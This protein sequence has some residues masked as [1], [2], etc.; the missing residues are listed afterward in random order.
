M[1]S[2]LKLERELQ[3][4]GIPLLATDEPFNVEGINA[5]TILVRRVKQ[6]VAIRKRVWTPASEWIWT[7]THP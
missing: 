1:Y 4:Q 6:G 5:T 7:P 2:S 3:N